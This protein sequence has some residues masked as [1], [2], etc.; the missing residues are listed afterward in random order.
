MQPYRS[1]AV[2]HLAANS[3]VRK[4]DFSTSISARHRLSTQGTVALE[5]DLQAACNLQ[6]Y[7]LRVLQKRTRP[8]VTNVRL[9]VAATGHD[10]LSVR[11]PC[12]HHNGIAV[13]RQLTDGRVCKRFAWNFLNLLPPWIS[14]SCRCVFIPLAILTVRFLLVFFLLEALCVC[15]A[16]CDG[17]CALQRSSRS[18]ST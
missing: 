8:P 6:S 18:C 1:K 14:R 15:T 16:A 11:G 4:P 12:H 13:V 3:V 10:A 5:K 2:R 17:Q 7:A 9:V